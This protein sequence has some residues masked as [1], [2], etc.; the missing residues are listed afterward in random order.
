MFR[1]WCPDRTESMGLALEGVGVLG[2]EA[3]YGKDPGQKS[4][5]FSRQSSART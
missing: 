2:Y 5:R 3:H 1:R 4:G